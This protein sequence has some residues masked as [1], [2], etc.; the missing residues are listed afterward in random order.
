VGLH[1]DDDRPVV[2]EAGRRRLDLR[3]E[4]GVREPE[5]LLPRARIEGLEHRK[6]AGRIRPAS[7][8]EDEL[9]VHDGALRPV[10][11]VRDDGSLEHELGADDEER[12]RVEAVAAAGTVEG[13][14]R[15]RVA[16]GRASFEAAELVVAQGTTSSMLARGC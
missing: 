11:V 1:G 5:P 13:E 12:E 8:D 4:I 15:R 16:G 10:P 6:G 3:R 14:A 2:E 7:R 9:V